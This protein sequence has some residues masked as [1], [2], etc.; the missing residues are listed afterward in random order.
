[1]PETISRMAALK[2]FFEADNG[3]K[4]DMKTDMLEFK[5]VDPDGFAELAG[6]AATALGKTLANQ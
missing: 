1:M 3:R 6:M 5:R 2:E 4:L